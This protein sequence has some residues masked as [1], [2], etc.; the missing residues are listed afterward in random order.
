MSGSAAAGGAMDGGVVNGRTTTRVGTGARGAASRWAWVPGLRPA[1][2]PEA[3]LE[4]GPTV[5]GGVVRLVTGLIV[6]A[7]L[8][9]GWS[10][11]LPLSLA[12][13]LVSL[14]MA[15][16]VV[17]LPRASLVGL[18]VAAVGLEVLV[19]GPPSVFLTLTLVLLVHLAVWA[20]G[21][22]ARVGLRARVELAVLADGLREV[23]LLQ[24]PAQLLAVGALALAGAQLDAGDVWRILALVAG[25]GV[26]TLVLPRRG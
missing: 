4:V 17:L 20:S 8:V 24:V 11:L 7:M 9:L 1:P 12:S 25:A 6:T 16:A 3:E 22:T 13:A 5:S 18:A 14:L 26:A 21:W 23:A 10:V 15:T 2:E 19:G